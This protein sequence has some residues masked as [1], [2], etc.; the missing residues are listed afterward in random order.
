MR[1]ADAIFFR[2]YHSGEDVKIYL[3][4]ITQENIG[5]WIHSFLSVRTQAIAVDGAK[6]QH[7][8][9]LS[10]VPQGSVLGPVLFLIM[11]GD[12]NKDVKNSRLSSFADDTRI[13]KVITDHQ[14]A[15]DLQADLNKVTKGA[16]DNN[17]AFNEN[18]F[19]LL[20]Y[21]NNTHL[22]TSQYLV[23]NQK[24]E[25]KTSVKDLG[26]QVSND[27]QFAAHFD[28]ITRMARQMTG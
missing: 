27:F 22:E 24:I 9:V 1:G 21:G 25:E 16:S 13:S 2:S 17:M 4:K 20:R 7:S 15:Q 28:N 18:K 23:G 10:S 26:I 3:K 14:D 19:E 6:S 11:L 12:I 5:V 8:S